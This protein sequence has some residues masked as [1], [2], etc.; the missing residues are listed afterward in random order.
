MFV[1]DTHVG[2]SGESADIE[3][4]EGFAVVEDGDLSVGCFAL[5]LV[6]EASANGDDAFGP[7]GAGNHPAGDVHLVDALVPDIAVAVGPEPVPVIVD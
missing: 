6:A 2:L 7:H 3:H 1:G 5:V 4:K